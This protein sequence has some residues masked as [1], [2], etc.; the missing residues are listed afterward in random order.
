MIAI[1][2]TDNT[3]YYLDKDIDD[4]SIKKIDK[5]KYIGQKFL[6]DLQKLSNP[7]TTKNL[8]G[9]EFIEEKKDRESETLVLKIVKKDEET[10]LQT[11]NMIGE[12]YFNTQKTVYKIDIGLRFDKKDDNRVLEYLLNYASAIYPDKV[13]L[14]T[15]E[16]KKKD[17]SNSIIKNLL[18]NLF[19]HSASKAY[20][21]G[22]PAIH[23]EVHEKGYTLRGRIDMHRLITE[24]LPFKGVT[25]CIKNERLSVESIGTVLLK[26]IDIVQSKVNKDFPNLSQIKSSI[27]QADINRILTASVLKEALNHKVLNHPSFYEY[28]NTLYLASLIINGFKTPDPTEMNG[29]FYGYLVD[30]SKIWENFLVKHIEQAI[31]ENWEVI[32]EPKL[33]LFKNKTNLHNLTNTMYPDIVIKCENER[34]VMVFDAK[35]KSSEWFNR[36]DFYKTATYISYYTNKGYKVVLSG[37]IYPDKNLDEINTNVGFLDSDVDFRFFGV[38]IICEIR[39]QKESA[40][41]GIIKEIVN[42]A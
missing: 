19:A 6:N 31:N 18:S 36:E 38:D 25:P 41:V 15:K 27:L 17:K 30:I 7:L 20:I 12:F 29:V 42:Q 4:K 21:M 40:L 39:R 16:K 24:E 28:R 26:A 23:H 10:Y 1:D 35:F 9:V 8:D 5:K 37:Q 22:L 34:K 2:L 14:G 32:P 33:K 3:R 11:G 13:K